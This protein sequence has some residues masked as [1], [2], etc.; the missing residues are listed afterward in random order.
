[1]HAGHDGGCDHGSVASLWWLIVQCF[2]VSQWPCRRHV[3]HLYIYM[4]PYSAI[5]STAA[6]GRRPSARLPDYSRAR[7]DC[8]ELLIGALRKL[9][10]I[11]THGRLQLVHLRRSTPSGKW[12]RCSAT[13]S[14]AEGRICM[15][16]RYGLR[17]WIQGDD[18]I[19]RR[20]AAHLP[21]A[22]TL[23]PRAR[24]LALSRTGGPWPPVVREEAATG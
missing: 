8:H 9:D 17:R 4:G 6:A 23:S 3:G 18:T 7:P 5:Q 14:R 16:I 13:V 24:L 1:M 22:P 19:R 21:R 15:S 12:R 10:A 2:T 20:G 11:A